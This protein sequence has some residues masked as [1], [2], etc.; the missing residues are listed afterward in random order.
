MTKEDAAKL[1]LEGELGKMSDP[2]ELR[3]FVGGLSEAEALSVAELMSRWRG[4]GVYAQ[5]SGTQTWMEKVAPLEEIFLGAINPKADAVLKT[6]ECNAGRLKE[7]E[8]KLI[9]IDEFAQKTRAVEIKKLLARKTARGYDLI[10]GN[11]RAIAMILFSG[12][13]EIT[14]LVAVP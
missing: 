14:L 3:R 5:I 2:T 4:N 8:D 10:D 12:A 13:R 6:I 1:Y 11:H 7:V 9:A